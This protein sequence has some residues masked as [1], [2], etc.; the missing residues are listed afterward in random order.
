LVLGSRWVADRG[1]PHLAAAARNALQKIAAVL[2]ADLRESLDASNLLVGPDVDTSEQTVNSASVLPQ[3][4]VAIRNERKLQMQY[5]DAKGKKS[6]R[7]VW[8]FALGFFE[9]VRVLVAWCE[10]RKEIRHFRTDRISDLM[11]LDQRYPK[12]RQALLKEWRSQEGIAAQ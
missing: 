7:I 6:H 12:R 5:S 3:L 9:H 2:P 4:R 8:P 10:L 1:D 11:M